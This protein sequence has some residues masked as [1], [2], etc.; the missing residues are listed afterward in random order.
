MRTFH[1][2]MAWIYWTCQETVGGGAGWVR[3]GVRGMDA[4]AKPPGTGSRR[5]PRTQ[6]VPP[7]PQPSCCRCRCS[8]F[9][10]GCRAAGPAMQEPHLP[11]RRL[12]LKP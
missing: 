10:G 9:K 1:P 8:G 12:C 4:A 2:R 11:R 3:G 5:P 6:P 7:N